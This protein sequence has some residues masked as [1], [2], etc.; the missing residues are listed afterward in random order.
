MARRRSVMAR[1]YLSVSLS[2]GEDG[3]G[4]VVRERLTRFLSKVRV[5]RVFWPVCFEREARGFP[6][7]PSAAARLLGRAAGI[8]APPGYSHRPEAVGNYSFHYKCGRGEEGFKVS[9]FR[10]F[11]VSRETPGTP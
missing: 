2:S 9:R 11:K 1:P 5:A 7:A 10:G 6:L 8:A 4:R 3:T